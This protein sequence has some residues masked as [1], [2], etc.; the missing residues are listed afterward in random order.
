[1]SHAYHEALPDFVPDAL[2][3]TGC[4]ECEQR[5]AFPG[6]RPFAHMD[7]PT[8]RRAFDRA[9]RLREGGRFD[10]DPLEGPA[11]RLLDELRVLVLNAAGSGLAQ[12]DYDRAGIDHEPLHVTI[13]WWILR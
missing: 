7:A 3:H 10:V 4:A 1:M 11:L 8:L 5:A 9:Q 6:L 12:V 13:P 2:F